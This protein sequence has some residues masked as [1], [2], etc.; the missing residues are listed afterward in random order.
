M[1]DLTNHLDS[2]IEEAGNPFGLELSHRTPERAVFRLDSVAVRGQCR[3][4]TIGALSGA[5]ARAQGE[6]GPALKSKKVNIPTAKGAIEFS[7]ADL[8]SVYDAIRKPLAAQEVCVMQFLG[9]VRKAWTDGEG[10]KSEAS[11]VVVTTLLSHSSGEWA[12]SELE[13]LTSTDP[14]QVGGNATYARR[15]ALCAMVGVAS[16][17]ED[18]EAIVAP[19][20]PEPKADRATGTGGKQFKHIQTGSKPVEQPDPS[21][22]NYDP[23]PPPKTE[24]PAHGP[25]A[26]KL[27]EFCKS[28]YPDGP[29]AALKEI[30]GGAGLKGATE[31]QAGKWLTAAERDYEEK[32]CAEVPF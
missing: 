16:E 25:N 22:V 10:R 15:Y 5:L 26:K 27:W 31:D 6:F 28:S 7:Y 24:K 30:T 18:D 21:S 8:S 17:D 12:Q 3:S 32:L 13:M 14:K 11:F 2:A 23:M 19:P 20:K 1:S 9:L 29:E 4:A